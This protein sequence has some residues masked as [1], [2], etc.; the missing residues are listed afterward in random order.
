M[1]LGSGDE[2]PWAPLIL[3][4]S[5]SPEILVFLALFPRY[6]SCILCWTSGISWWPMEDP[7][8]TGPGHALHPNAGEMWVPGPRS[9]WGSLAALVSPGG[10]IKLLG[11]WS[12]R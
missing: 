8:L 10:G 5:I 7:T 6:L 3:K 12:Q 4:P 9:S 2:C 1:G 11:A